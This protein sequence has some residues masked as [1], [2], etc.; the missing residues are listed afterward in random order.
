MT[1]EEEINQKILEEFENFKKSVKKPNILL[2]GG[3]GVGKSSLIN[4][5]FGKEKTFVYKNVD[6]NIVKDGVL[7]ESPD[8]T[9]RCHS[10]FSEVERIL[11][12]DFRYELQDSLFDGRL[13]V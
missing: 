2:A 13:S 4:K 12:D 7:L 5:I 8:G 3:T 11:C 9:V 1:L 10:D 6:K